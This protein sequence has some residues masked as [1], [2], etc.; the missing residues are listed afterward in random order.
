MNKGWKR[1]WSVI[2]AI[3]LVALVLA[4]VTY[5]M[6]RSMGFFRDPVFESERPSL[7][8]LAHPA[9]LVFSK[10]NAFIHKEA[11]PVAKEMLR[12]MAGEHGWS[13]VVSD[14][15][16]LF[17]AEDLARFDVVVWNNVSGDVLLPEQREAFRSWLE[18]GGGFVGLHAAGDNSHE[19]WPWYQDNVIRAHFDG[20][21]VFPQFQQ[22]RLR[23]EQPADPLVAALPDPWVRTDEWYTFDDSPRAAD[24][25]VLVTIDENSYSPEAFGFLSLRMGE[26]HPLIWKHC[27]GEGRVFYSALGHTAGTYTEPEYR[28][29]LARAIAWAGRIGADSVVS[30]G[31]L[32]CESH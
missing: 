10:A 9:V 12:Q 18:N 8:P 31:D 23:V 13:V 14:S 22:A 19:V 16:A 28:E 20:H 5:G 1:F 6:G 15:G 27:V 32:A 30:A 4:G 7:P 25:R 11:I 29:L 21:P 24:L 2:V 26:D 17:N 3:M